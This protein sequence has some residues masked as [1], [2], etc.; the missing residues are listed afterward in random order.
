MRRWSGV[1]RD[2][3]GDAAGGCARVLAHFLYTIHLTTGALGM[4]NRG[5]LYSRNSTLLCRD[6]VPYRATAA[7]AILQFVTDSDSG[8]PPSRSPPSKTAGSG[9]VAPSATL[10]QFDVDPVQAVEDTALLP[11]HSCSQVILVFISPRAARAPWRESEEGPPQR[12]YCVWPDT[13]SRERERRR[14]SPRG[15]LR[16]LRPSIGR[17]RSIGSAH[18]SRTPR[19][20]PSLVAR[21]QAARWA[22]RLVGR[23]SARAAA[24]RSRTLTARSSISR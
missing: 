19:V 1:S 2:S 8:S 22:T 20:T 12:A 9:R 3:T 24:A 7:G 14:E 13:H 18:D 16:F 21:A 4:R 6:L 10:Q 17:S 23:R 11:R 5:S 15:P